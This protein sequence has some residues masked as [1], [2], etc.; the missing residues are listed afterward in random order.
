[1]KTNLSRWTGL[2]TLGQEKAGQRCQVALMLAGLLAASPLWGQ[3]LQYTYDNSG[4]VTVRTA[5]T[6]AAPQILAQP[7]NQVVRPGGLASFSVLLADPRGCAYQWQFNGTNL[8]RNTSDAL[9]LAN[10]S[11]NN[12]GPYAVVVANSSGNVTSIVAQLY[13]DTRG[14]GMPDSWQLAYFGNLNQNALADNDG[15]GIPNLQE[16]LDGTNPTNRTSFRSRLTVLGDG[17]VV[18]VAPEQASYA[19]TDTVTLTGTPFAGN[20]FFGWMGD[21]VGGAN[22]ATLLMGTNK[23]VRGCFICQPAVAGLVAWWRGDTDASD[24]VG[25][26]NGTCYA[27]ISNVLAPSITPTGM[28]GGAF[29]QYGTNYVQVP[30]A[31]DLKPAQFTLAAW[32]FPTVQNNN[33]QTGVAKGSAANDDDAY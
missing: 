5:E 20:S 27:G 9:L 19:L 33:Y 6:A 11:T 30:D 16:F 12:Q 25:L 7:Q 22:P 14:C 18:S 15:D 32:I 13:I 23:T 10:V 21:L 3:A 28:V 4:N 17:G 26:H 24:I 31:T 2:G 1:M 8:P 29:V